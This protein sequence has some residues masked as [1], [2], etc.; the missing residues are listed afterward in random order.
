MKEM[1]IE[2][3]KERWGKEEAD[4]GARQGGEGGGKK[5]KK[6]KEKKRKTT[7]AGEARGSMQ[8]CSLQTANH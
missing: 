4:K 6:K 3:G 1:G 7:H 8:I 2:W 5:Q